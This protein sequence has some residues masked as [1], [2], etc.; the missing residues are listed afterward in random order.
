MQIK[1]IYLDNSVL[2]RPFDDQGQPRIRLEAQA[3]ASILGLVEQRVL[4][5]ASSSVQ[6][7]ENEQ[8]PFPDRKRWVDRCLR[9]AE[10]RGVVDAKTIGRAHELVK[11]GQS[12]LDALHLACAEV[13][14][15]QYFLTCDDRL[16]KRY[17]GPLGVLS[18]AV[19]IAQSTGA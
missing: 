16:A 14:R 7:F 11:Q 18:P 19:F 1:R 17:H 8:N 15:S 5:L 9:L 12:P 10:I 4:E 3:L 13:C 2:N 6:E